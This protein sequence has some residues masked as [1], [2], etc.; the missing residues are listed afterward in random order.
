[1]LVD[2]ALGQYLGLQQTLVCSSVMPHSSKLTAI[3]LA[4]CRHSSLLIV[5][6][7]ASRHCK[8]PFTPT[9]WLRPSVALGV[10]GP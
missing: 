1:V 5:T 4:M 3:A 2:V 7:L 6:L 8:D 9:A 10:N